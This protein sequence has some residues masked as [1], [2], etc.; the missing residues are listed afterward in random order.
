LINYQVFI[1]PRNGQLT[2]GDE[3][4]ITDFVLENSISPIRVGIDSTDYDIGIFFFDDVQLTMANIDGYFN[5]D[6]DYRSIFPYGRDK[7]KCRVVYRDSKNIDDGTIVFNGLVADEA[8]RIDAQKDEIQFRVLS[9]YSILKDVNV[10]GGTI[11]DGMLASSA[12]Y[13]ILNVPKITAVLNVDA[14]N[15]NPANDIVIDVGSEISSKSVKDALNQ[16]LLAT[17]SVILVDDDDN[18]LIQSRNETNDRPVLELFGPF[19]LKRRENIIDIKNYNTGKQRMFTAV[20]VNDAQEVNNGHIDYYG[21]KQKTIDMPFITDQ[22]T[23]RLIASELL[24]EFKTPKIELEV[25][26]PTSIARG[27]KPLDRVSIDHPLR[28]IPV[29]GTFLPIVDEAVIGDDLTPIPKTTGSISIEPQM[30]FKI[31]EIK[32]DPKSFETSLKLRQIGIDIGDGYFSTSLCG[33]INYAI[34]GISQICEDGD[35]ADS[36]NPSV[37]GAAVIGYTE[38]S[39]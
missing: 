2:Y 1:T 19:D 29:D 3:I 5:D 16:L 38:V 8:T 22:T 15:I 13:S 14:L 11:T 26:V 18:I 34:V 7:A 24:A 30:G 4:E 37:V 27:Y 12:F 23:E 21:Y 20:Q 35:I 28:I 25:T 6:Q 9:K 17:N 33:I 32:E 36:F 39:V 10:S 31:L